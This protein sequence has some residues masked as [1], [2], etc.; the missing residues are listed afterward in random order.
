VRTPAQQE[1][2][3]AKYLKGWHTQA[4]RKKRDKGLSRTRDDDWTLNAKVPREAYE[5]RRRQFGKQYWQE[6]G[7]RALKRDG[8]LIT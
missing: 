3:Y 7:K 2:F 1:R 4:R 8:W 6:E 5:A